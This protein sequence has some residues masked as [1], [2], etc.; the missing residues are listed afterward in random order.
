M[1]AYDPYDRGDNPWLGNL[2]MPRS[3]PTAKPGAGRALAPAK[4]KKPLPQRGPAGEA[5]RRPAPQRGPSIEAPRRP[6]ELRPAAQPSEGPFSPPAIPPR[7]TGPESTAKLAGD[8]AITGG[9]LA[10]PTSERMYQDTPFDPGPP[11]PISQAAVFPTQPRPIM[12]SGPP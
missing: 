5:P 1:L 7:V 12:P 8:P 9:L 11:P 2:A 6:A 4:K 10:G 3:N